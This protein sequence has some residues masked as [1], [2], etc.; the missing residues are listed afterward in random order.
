MGEHVERRAVIIDGGAPQIEGRRVFGIVMPYDE[1]T[2]IGSYFETF[3]PR[4]FGSI[5]DEVTLNLH[6]DRHRVIAR[7]GAGLT[8]EDGRK[9]LRA[10]IEVPETRDG[11]DALTLLRHRVLR[12]FSVE[13]VA[14][15]QTWRRS[16]RT[17]R[18]AVLVGVGLVANPAYHGATA[19]AR[20]QAETYMR[21]HL[22]TRR[23]L[24]L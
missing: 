17:I 14:R 16:L 11:D 4:A 21:E 2:S 3:E 12:G 20:E 5:A 6:H 15:Q 23:R 8:F 22:S 19:E 10:S 18:Q 24:W 1:R 7:N 13:F 9:A